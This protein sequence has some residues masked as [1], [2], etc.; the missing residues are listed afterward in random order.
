MPNS[1]QF[2]DKT[3]KSAEKFPIID[4]KLCEF[5]GVSPDPVKYHRDWYNSF[6]ECAA[7][8]M[9]FRKMVDEIYV[10]SD[11][12]IKRMLEWLDE[13]YFTDAWYSVGV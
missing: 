12:E 1:F 2:I 8:G 7:M 9:S 11:D 5:L 3:T 10:N 6:G 4:D 13:H